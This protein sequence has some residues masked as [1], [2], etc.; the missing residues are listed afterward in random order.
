MFF[1]LNGSLLRTC[2][3]I[4]NRLCMVFNSAK[5]LIHAL[6]TDTFSLGNQEP[7]VEEPATCQC[8]LTYA[9]TA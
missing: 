5:Q 8:I 4:V 9:I 7:D 6:Q 3:D 2:S 1:D